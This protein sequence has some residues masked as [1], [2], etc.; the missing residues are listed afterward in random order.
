MEQKRTQI[1][2]EAMLKALKNSLGIVSIACEKAGINRWTHYDWLKTDA[3]YK[4]AVENIENEALDL[5]EAALL[6]LIKQKNV[7]AIIFLLRTRGKHRGYTEKLDPVQPHKINYT[8]R[9]IRADK[10]Q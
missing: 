2:K 5:A 4:R 7:R 3:Q 1:K 8:F 9:L 10:G 6:T